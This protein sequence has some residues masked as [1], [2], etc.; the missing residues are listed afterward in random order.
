MSGIP[1]P[2]TPLHTLSRGSIHHKAG[3]YAIWALALA[4]IFNVA[5]QGVFKSAGVTISPEVQRLSSLGFG[6]IFVSA[7]PAGIIALCGIGKYGRK[8][9]LVQ[10]LLGTLVP[11]ILIGLAIPAFN[12][13][14][15]SSL[16]ALARN[17]AA[18]LA[19]E[20]SAGTP[21]MLDEVTQLDGAKVGPEKTVTINL[22]LTGFTKKEIDPVTWKEKVV[23][24]VK[25]NV[26]KPPLQNLI[27][28]GVTI[29]YRYVDRE[30]TLVDEL[31][32]RPQDY[33]AKK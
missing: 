8:P 32:F 2:T 33:P 28:A 11:L 14:R 27:R 26:E 12:K 22:T 13:V 25:S 29:V 17:Q 18:T 10:G 1:N 4:G 23:A 6:L 3:R 7:I 24:S 9:L 31:V 21:K 15:T 20:V 16:E 19:K 30:G 5:T